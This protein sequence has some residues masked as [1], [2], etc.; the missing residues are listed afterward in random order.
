MANSKDYLA[1]LGVV[2]VGV[3]FGIGHFGDLHEIVFDSENE[4]KVVASSHYDDTY[5][6]DYKGYYHEISFRGKKYS[7]S[8]GCDCSGF[9]P[10]TNGDEW[11]KSI[12]KHCGHKKS[13]H[14]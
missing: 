8:V 11:Q 14:K 9:D 1:P 5:S 4:S 10:T 3:I 2:V 12:C 6:S 13:C 7:G